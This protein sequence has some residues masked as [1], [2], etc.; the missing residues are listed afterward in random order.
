MNR[1][2]WIVYVGAG[3]LGEVAGK[4]ITEDNFIES[5]IGEASQQVE[6]A[7]RISLAVAAVVTGITLARRSKRTG[8]PDQSHS[9]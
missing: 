2:S 5:T 4:M 3:I 8:F 9:T 1:Y 6:W 7:I